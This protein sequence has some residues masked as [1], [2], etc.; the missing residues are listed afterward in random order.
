M[1]SALKINENESIKYDVEAEMALNNAPEE[2]KNV[3]EECMAMVE[4]RTKIYKKAAELIRITGNMDAI[5][6]DEMAVL[7]QVFD[8]KES[9][10]AAINTIY[11]IGMIDGKRVARNER[12]MKTQKYYSS[13][14]EKL[15]SEIEEV[16]KE[17]DHLNS[18][19]VEIK[20]VSA[21][22]M[23]CQV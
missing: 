2:V 11:S 12:K 7:E 18:V 6:G 5:M 10:L 15:K 19:L 8:D 3:F 13:E 14:I 21:K 1:N 17:R 4:R 9:K 23:Y 16:T 22:Y 20:M